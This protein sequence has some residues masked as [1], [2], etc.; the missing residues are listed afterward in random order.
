MN[1]PPPHLS[2]NWKA[3]RTF[4]PGTRQCFIY[5]FVCFQGMLEGLLIHM[6]EEP[7]EFLIKYLERDN[8]DGE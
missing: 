1:T 5:V 6:P 7:V 3:C 2:V 8:E 4:N